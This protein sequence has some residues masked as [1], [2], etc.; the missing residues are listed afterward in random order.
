MTSK[1]LFLLSLLWMLLFTT[2]QAQSPA[3]STTALPVIDVTHIDVMPP[4]IT[5][6]TELL[7]TYMNET[8]KEKGLISC[9]VYQQVGR[10]NHYTLVE[11]WVDQAACD[12][13]ISQAHTRQF[14]D[15]IQP[16]LGGPLDERLHNELQ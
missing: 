15:K 4:Y 3:G 9:K 11:E 10:L 6:A 13:H 8:R 7:H 16:M 5:N 2:T 1:K 12:A 14:R